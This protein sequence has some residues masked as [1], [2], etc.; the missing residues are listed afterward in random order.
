MLRQWLDIK[1]H[2]VGSLPQQ[3]R[4]LPTDRGPLDIKGPVTPGELRYLNLNHDLDGFRPP[5]RQQEALVQIARLPEGRVYVACSGNTIIGYVT[6]HGPEE[7]ERWGQGGIK[8]IMELGA[9]EIGRSWRGV[10][11]A[12]ALLDLIF[13]EDWIEDYIIIACEY[14]WHW[15][16]EG[17]GLSVWQYR[18][19]MENLLGRFGMKNTG[20]DD[21]DICDHPANM[22]AVR[23][24]NRVSNEATEAFERLRFRR[25][26]IYS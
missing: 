1:K 2:K 9:I 3:H 25:T 11:A 15:D 21:P 10:G 4:V 19:M 26:S 24:G 5:D 22:L 20:T 18:A 23:I 12:R 16:L 7:F 6:F 13:A 14:C 8:E 17:T